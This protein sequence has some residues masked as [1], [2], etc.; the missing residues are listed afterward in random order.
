MALANLS[1]PCVIPFVRVRACIYFSYTGVYRRTVCMVCM[2]FDSCEGCEVMWLSR[3][4]GIYGMAVAVFI[5][6]VFH[7]RYQ[8]SH[9]RDWSLL[10]TVCSLLIYIVIQNCSVHL[11]AFFC[12]LFFFRIQLHNETRTK[13]IAAWRNL[14]LDYHRITKQHLLD[15]REAQRTPL[16]NNTTIDSIL[17]HLSF[18]MLW[19]NLQKIVI[20]EI[21][22]NVSSLR[23]AVCGYVFTV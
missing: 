5:P 21:R 12:F 3:Q 4:D 17:F 8:Y 16:F 13:Q 20:K 18:Y 19:R 11:I 1:L 2:R 9:L 7:V 6:A 15:V 14:V 23:I 10:Y 22:L